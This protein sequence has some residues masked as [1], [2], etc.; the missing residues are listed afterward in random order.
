[1]KKRLIISVLLLIM[2]LG[3]M[4]TVHAFDYT[5]TMNGSNKVIKNQEFTVDVNVSNIVSE[6]GVISF[7]G[8]LEYDKDSLELVKFEGKNGWETPTEGA[9]YGSDGTIAITRNG[10]TKDNGT[11]FT[12]TFKAKD[13]VKE[14]VEIKLKT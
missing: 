5:V 12:V 9:T 1:M 4:S 2:T 3:I 6:R 11:I 7:G 13:V 8:T 10:V 14:K